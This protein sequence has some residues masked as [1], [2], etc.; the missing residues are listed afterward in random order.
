M[1]RRMNA[2]EF[3]C[4][5]G[6]VLTV[7]TLGA[8]ELGSISGLRAVLQMGLALYMAVRNGLHAMR[9]FCLREERKANR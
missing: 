7:G 2:Y 1:L 3:L 4:L 9:L 8:I 6:V 5:V